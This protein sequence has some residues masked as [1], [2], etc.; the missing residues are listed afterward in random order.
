[1]LTSTLLHATLKSSLERIVERLLSSVLATAM[2]SGDSELEMIPI[3]SSK[4]RSARPALSVMIS[5]LLASNTPSRLSTSSR[6][7]W[8]ISIRVCDAPN[9][10]S[11]RMR[12]RLWLYNVNSSLIQRRDVS[13]VLIPAKSLSIN[14]SRFTSACGVSS[15]LTYMNSDAFLA[16][17]SIQKDPFLM[18]SCFSST[19]TTVEP[20][21]ITIIESAV[22]AAVKSALTQV[23]SDL[24]MSKPAMLRESQ[25]SPVQA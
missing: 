11:R 24:H 22:Q 9:R 2:M 20:Q 17:S 6:M 4:L 16:A 23:L 13:S 25:H 19:I 18:G 7:V 10:C 8:S 21:V 5:S 1:M 12:A 15:T 3:S 14:S